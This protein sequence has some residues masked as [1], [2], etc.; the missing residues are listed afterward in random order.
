M[1]YLWQ[2][3]VIFQPFKKSE[4]LTAMK[5]PIIKKKPTKKVSPKKKRAPRK[6]LDS[7]TDGKRIMCETRRQFEKAGFTEIKIAKELAGMAF[8]RV[9]LKK[10]QPH[11][12]LQ[13]LGMAVDVI[14]I[15]KPAKIDVNHKGAITINL[16][17]RFGK[18]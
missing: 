17:D 1:Y 10:L 15:K 3:F 7:I 4:I 13:A 9:D 5:K 18:A 16:I 2:S 14:G 12:K 8:A 11:D 6:P